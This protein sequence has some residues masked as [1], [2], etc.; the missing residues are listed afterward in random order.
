MMAAGLSYEESQT[1]INELALAEHVCV[2]CVNSPLSVTLSGSRKHIDMLSEELG[3]RT[4]F[5]RLLETGGRAYHSPSMKPVGE[6]YQSLLDAFLA[7][8]PKQKTIRALMFSTVDSNSYGPL[9]LDHATEMTS[10]WRANMEKPVQFSSALASI[11]SAQQHHLI[12]LGPHSTLKGPIRQILAA[13]SMA[14]PYT[15]SLVR[16][17]NSSACLKQ[18]AGVLFCQ[19]HTLDW[20]N[21]NL[22]SI[23]GQRMADKI[24]PYPWDY[25]N[26]LNW[27][28][29]RA[30]SEM[31]TRR[32]ARHELL[33]SAQ[34]TGN[35]IDWSWRN[36]LLVQE[37][38]W[39]QDH[40]VENQI[41]FPAAAY[42]S[43]A[44]EAVSQIQELVE[45]SS[46]DLSFEF[47]NVCLNSALVLETEPHRD[48]TELHTTMG[49][50]RISGR[51][52]SSTY[53]DFSVSSWRLGHAVVHCSG[54]IRI[55][56]SVPKNG[57]V[58]VLDKSG[59]RS[60][61]MDRWYEQ[62]A[63]EGL[64]FGPHLQSITSLRADRNRATTDAICTTNTKPPA[65]SNCTSCGFVH[66]IVLDACLQAGILSAAAGNPKDLHPYLPISIERCLI[67]A[68]AFDGP[69]SEAVI[70]VRSQKTGVSKLMAE[71]TLQ[72]LQSE[73]LIDFD[74]IKFSLYDEKLSKRAEDDLHL[75]R[76]PVMRVQWK[77]DLSL[78]HSG[79]REQLD[80]HISQFLVDTIHVNDTPRHQSVVIGALLDLLGHKNPQMRVLDFGAHDRPESQYY[81]EI[82]D[83]GSAF[84]RYSSWDTLVLANEY[85]PGTNTAENSFD[86]FVC[87]VGE[88]ISFSIMGRCLLKYTNF[89]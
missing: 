34:L 51:H 5:C 2:A 82:L 1:L 44:I 52:T 53:Y 8:N 65:F 25:S 48:N 64:V 29:S 18:L 3:A 58:N 75:Q 73:P 85:H 59:Y 26:G 54:S 22:V 68:S 62:A 20:R 31:R 45:I 47:Q 83:K 7:G 39:L 69:G 56:S 27:F 80:A 55:L 50:R 11:L 88:L 17:Q 9:I 28:E 61:P 86:V 60:W 4:K 74:G 84:P 79:V 42:L 81:L 35:G 76:H 70:H 41:V 12:E 77:P 21:I 15:P 78:T 10:Y 33:G 66:P 36:T 63:Q 38:P 46:K 87:E 49:S 43:M 57:L 89:G 24:P 19:G 23:C 71:C 16:N 37:V 67:H 72:S 13:R 30:A 14:S 32:H 6:L 40:K